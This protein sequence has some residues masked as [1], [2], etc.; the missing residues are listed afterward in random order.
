MAFRKPEQRQLRGKPKH[1]PV[2]HDAPVSWEQ[3]LRE[4]IERPG[5]VSEAFRRFHNYSLGNALLITWQCA[6]SGIE[7]GPAASFNRWRELGRQVRKGESALLICMPRPFTIKETNRET[8]KEEERRLTRFI[9]RKVVFVYSQTDPIPG[10]EDKSAQLAGFP[11]DWSVEQAMRT[12]GLTFAPF[13][14]TRGNCQGYFDPIGRTISL[15]PMGEHPERTALHEIAHSQLHPNGYEEAKGV[16][17]FEAEATAL[18]VSSA[19]GLGGA[20]ESRGY[21]QG[22]LRKAGAT[23][24]S[25]RTASRIFAKAQAILKAG[26]APGEQDDQAAA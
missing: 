8:G 16:C 11:D 19:L 9:Y 13:H 10:A 15:N 24:I 21:C 22:W 14:D 17:E 23:D 2:K 26:Y 4:A 7:L 18:L 6:A 1:E 25:E 20:D 3:L 12:F 5:V